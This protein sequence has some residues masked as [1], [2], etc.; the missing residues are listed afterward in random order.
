[1]KKLIT[2]CF[3]L[4]QITI[5]AQEHKNSVSSCGSEQLNK[6]L[7]QNSPQLALKMANYEK[8]VQS[9]KMTAK[10]SPTTYKIPVVVHV[11]HKGENIGEGTNLSDATIITKIKAINEQFRKIPGSTGDGTGVDM[12]IEF[13]L[14]VVNPEGNQTNG[15][16]RYDMSSQIAYMNNGINFYNTN[17]I[18]QSSLKALAFWDSNLYYNIWIVSEVDNNN[19]QSGIQGAAQPATM[20]G[21]AEDGFFIVSNSFKDPF[22][23]METHELGHAFNLY[24]TF[25][26]DNPSGDGVT[27]VCPTDNPAQGDFCADTAPHIR[28]TSG[29]CSATSNSCYPD[30]TDLSYLNNYMNYTLD[31]CRNMFTADQK[32]RAIT[33]LTTLRDSFLSSSSTD[34]LIPV[35]A[36]TAGFL[37][38]TPVVVLTNNDIQLS[39]ASFGV[40]SNYLNYYNWPAMSFNWNVNNGNT[41]LTSTDQNP[42]FNFPLEGIFNVS[43]DVNNGIGTSSKLANQL[44]YVIAPSVELP[45]NT[46]KST[47]SGDYS[48][49]YVKLNTIEKTISTNTNTVYVDYINTDNTLLIS[50]QNY[51]LSFNTK[52][53]TRY[54]EFFAVYIDWNGNGNFE[55]SEKLGSSSIPAGEAVARTV[56]VL[57]PTNAVKNK[58]LRMRVSGNAN[59]QI[60]NNMINGKSTFFIGDNKDFGIYVIDQPTLSTSDFDASKLSFYPN[61][62]KDVLNINYN[63]AIEKVEIY[64]VLGQLLLTKKPNLTKINMNLSH[65][66]KGAYIATIY[67]N[68]NKSSIKIL[69]E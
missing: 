31:G 15:I 13:I 29:D 66:N 9:R 37:P 17:G 36:P 10:T 18:S 57:V 34:N 46:L 11:M 3:L 7:I 38:A 39:D 58:L 69:K 49:N 64:N 45:S 68:G 1:M 54:K 12:E 63:V 24:H 67:S 19:G 56:P 8:A 51:P 40:P 50:G 14:A 55:E 65:L 43:H 47:Q 4:S 26:G 2:L 28:V 16:D 27:F 32:N 22:G 6:Q 30:N 35:T 23:R 48:N 52:A 61:P 59:G 62:V 60:T 44:I 33:A 20:H 21:T 41:T 42:V 25:Q 53:G 5:F